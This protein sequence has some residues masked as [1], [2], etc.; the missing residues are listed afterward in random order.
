M[1]QASSTANISNVSPTRWYFIF[2]SIWYKCSFPG[3]I[4]SPACCPR[5]P[6]T[7]GA[8]I[9]VA[10]SSLPA[11]SYYRF[12]SPLSWSWWC[13]LHPALFCWPGRRWMGAPGSAAPAEAPGAA[14][15]GDGEPCGHP[16]HAEMPC[17]CQAVSDIAMWAPG[18]L[19][20][21]SRTH[22]SAARSG[23]CRERPELRTR[24]HRG[25]LHRGHVSLL[26][27]LPSKGSTAL[28]IDN[29][30]WRLLLHHSASWQDKHG[31]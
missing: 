7:A 3:K 25:N 24:V 8:N 13:R 31:L 9:S 6:Q 27:I 23:G 16:A 17:I 14:G 26:P 28:T 1:G 19:H 21:A 10:F 20:C 18:L 11:I 4:P 5:L 22:R 15:D 29:V 2:G 12:P 30:H